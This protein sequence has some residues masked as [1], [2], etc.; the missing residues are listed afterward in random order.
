MSLVHSSYAGD[1]CAGLLDVALDWCEYP[2]P[3]GVSA[4]ATA[5]L[6][7]RN[8]AAHCPAEVAS[9]P[10]AMPALLSAMQAAA[11]A[12]QHGALA[13]AAAAVVALSRMREKARVALRSLPGAE[14][15]L[16]VSRDACRTAL[17]ESACAEAHRSLCE[18]ALEHLE[19]LI[20]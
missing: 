16:L 12:R 18:A 15:G 10:R 2:A 11:A 13:H 7:L 3:A 17:Q 14:Q 1:A 9:N 6:V 19:L 8:M 4:S 20:D 5:I